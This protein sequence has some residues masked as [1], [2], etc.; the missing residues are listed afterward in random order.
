MGSVIFFF[1]TPIQQIY[2]KDSDRWV[3]VWLH[4]VTLSINQLDDLPMPAAARYCARGQ[5]SPP[6]PT[7]STEVLDKFSW[8]VDSQDSLLCSVM[9]LISLDRMLTVLYIRIILSDSVAVP[10]TPSSGRRSCLLYR[11]MSSLLRAALA[12]RGLRGVTLSYSSSTEVWLWYHTR[13]ELLH[14]I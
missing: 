11:M 8:P 4:K 13:E 6:Q 10:C 3:N 2:F 12:F 7:I 14:K 5:P 1:S 9:P